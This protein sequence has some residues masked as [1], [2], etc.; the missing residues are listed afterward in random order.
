VN[1]Q[2]NVAQARDDGS[3]LAVLRREFDDFLEYLPDALVEI[4]LATMRVVRLNRMA[5]IITG[6]GAADV[7]DGMDARKLVID[8]DAA[9][10][11]EMS[12]QLIQRSIIDGVPYQRTGRQDLIEVTMVRKNDS[13]F[14]AEL[15]G[16]FVLDD[17]GQPSGVRGIFRDISER[18]AQDEARQRL[19]GDLQAALLE[20]RTLGG[21]LPICAWCHRVRD[22][23]GAWHRFEQYIRLNSGAEVTHGMCP[24]CAR[25][26]A[27]DGS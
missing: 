21:L 27:E 25:T 4:D 5:T 11:A 8:G 14:V 15:Q 19:I 2:R 20:V 1:S 13:R 26:V 17:R 3:G 24:D 6:Y 7:E 18:K 9:R 22:D 23:E 10:L 12:A 16:S